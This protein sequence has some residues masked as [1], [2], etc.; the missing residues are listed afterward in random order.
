MRERRL[1]HRVSSQD[2]LAIDLF[3]LVSTRPHFHSSKAFP[4]ERIS[5]KDTEKE[6]GFWK[7]ADR[8]GVVTVWEIHPSDQFLA[9]GI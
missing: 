7:V 3:L 5:G 9:F 4:S 8:N 6:P 2:K 1:L